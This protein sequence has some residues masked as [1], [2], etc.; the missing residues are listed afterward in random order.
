[1]N[2]SQTIIGKIKYYCYD[3][4]IEKPGFSHLHR[5]LTWLLTPIYNYIKDI[6]IGLYALVTYEGG[7]LAI[8]VFVIASLLGNF[9]GIEWYVMHLFDY[10]VGISLLTNVFKAVIDNISE[11]LLLSCFAGCFI[12]V[13]NIVS[14]NIYTPVIFEDDIPEEA[15]ESLLDCVIQVYT[16]G[17]INGDMD[18]IYADRFIFDTVYFIFMDILFSN[19]ISGIMI[20]GFGALKEEDAE[21][22]ADKK[23]KC[24]ICAM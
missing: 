3:F 19:L 5:F 2:Q 8:L 9:Y 24:F 10:F 21:R 4:L 6:L 15:C 14:L 17:A 7:F 12:M 22:Y 23:S 16:S 18:Q 13:F 1:M 20:D 11:L